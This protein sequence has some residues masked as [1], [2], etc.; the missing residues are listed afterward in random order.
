MLRLFNRLRY[1]ACPVVIPPMD[2]AV[3]PPSSTSHQ[4]AP[5]KYLDRN[6]VEK[7]PKTG[8]F[9][10]RNNNYFVISRLDPES[11]S[12]RCSNIRSEMMR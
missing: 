10:R 4:I 3:A 6:M 9:G 2:S 1:T 8:S 11:F 5:P 12:W 7:L